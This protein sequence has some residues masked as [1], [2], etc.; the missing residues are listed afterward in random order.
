MLLARLCEELVHL[1]PSLQAF[2]IQLPAVSLPAQVLAAALPS[3]DHWLK[4]SQAHEVAGFE[5]ML[6]HHGLP[7]CQKTITP[8]LAKLQ[9]EGAVR[10]PAVQEGRR[11]AGFRPDLREKAHGQLPIA[12][13]HH[14]KRVAGHGGRHGVAGRAGLCEEVLQRLAAPV[15]N[16]ALRAEH[17]RREPLRA[18]QLVAV[19]QA[20]GRRQGRR[21]V[22][23]HD[24]PGDAL[25]A[26]GGGI[27]HRQRAIAL[28]GVAQMRLLVLWVE[29]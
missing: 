2:G 22:R 4:S 1:V 29:R 19:Q 5:P 20:G 25:L 28:G 18:A 26:G 9:A 16:F 27:Q 14:S 8:H 15:A 10:V 24:S 17:L 3:R 21:K 12:Q 13:D 7:G 6:L 11:P 23:G